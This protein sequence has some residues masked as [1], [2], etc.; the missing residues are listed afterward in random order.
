MRSREAYLQADIEVLNG[1]KETTKELLSRA[2]KEVGELHMK[3]QQAIAQ[4]EALEEEMK[5]L[6][7][8]LSS[9]SE[10]NL[11][12]RKRAAQVATICLFVFHLRHALFFQIVM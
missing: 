12:S 10:T 4:Q 7:H 11:I 9:E 3:L 8:R 1:E 6:Q 2:R 5:L